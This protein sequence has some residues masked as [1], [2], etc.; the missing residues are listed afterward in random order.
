MSEEEIKARLD[1]L[2]AW[3][4]A[5]YDKARTE[6]PVFVKTLARERALVEIVREICSR[7]DSASLARFDAILHQK[8][9]FH[10]QRLLLEENDKQIAAEADRRLPSNPEIEENPNLFEG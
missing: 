10:Y 5:F 9:E 8:T 4:E 6:H 3:K 2:E 7:L 1:D